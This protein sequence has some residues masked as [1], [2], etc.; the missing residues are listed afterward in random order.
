MISVKP[1]YLVDILNGSKTLELR[2]YIP[3]DFKGWVNVYCSKAKPYL[4]HIHKQVRV[5]DEFSYFEL[6]H[7][8]IEE[9][10]YISVDR[11]N[12]K[13]VCRF[14]FDEYIAYQYYSDDNSYRPQT[15]GYNAEA[16]LQR[17]CLTRDEF[18]S[19][20]KGKDLYAWHI[21]Q[22]KIFDKP[23]ELGD[24]ANY[25]KVSTIFKNQING[26]SLF[27]NSIGCKYKEFRKLNNGVSYYGCKLQKDYTSDCDWEYCPLCKLT[28][29]PQTYAY[30]WTKE[31]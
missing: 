29:A 1:E 2:S 23:K 31:E 17:L 4:F 9:E 25:N 18:K 27:G 5:D 20:G 22:L 16:V 14:W 7:K 24:F 12:A 13:V 26:Q 30:V 15:W 11:L 3:K 10:R 21:K 19:Y 8:I 6:S 28:H